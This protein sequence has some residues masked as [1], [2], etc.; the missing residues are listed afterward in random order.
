MYYGAYA[1]IFNENSFIRKPIENKELVNKVNEIL[2]N[3]NVRRMEGN[4]NLFNSEISMLVVYYGMN[5][6]TFA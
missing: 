4:N 1:G 5:Q 3:N 2:L 6:V